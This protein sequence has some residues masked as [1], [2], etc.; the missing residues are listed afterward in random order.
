MA[1][2]RTL[3]AVLTTGVS[4]SALAWVAER[5]KPTDEYSMFVLRTPPPATFAEL[6][7]SVDLPA[8]VRI[9]SSESRR[10]E[11]PGGATVSTL[12]VAEI[13]ERGRSPRLDG[14]GDTIRIVQLGG[15]FEG[16]DRIVRATEV[17]HPPLVTGRSYLLALKWHAP[18]EAY[19]MPYGP[20]SVFE[21]GAGKVHPRAKGPAV[22]ELAGKNLPEA[23]RRMK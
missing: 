15:I 12:F 11:I 21:I 17:R 10:Q 6:V 3:V 19:V 13:L 20:N 23:I 4:A 16:P 2:M 22:L 18:E 9:R 14:P 7:D 1:L 8:Y 5:Q